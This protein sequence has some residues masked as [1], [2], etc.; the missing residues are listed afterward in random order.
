MAVSPYTDVE[1]YL[2]A[3]DAPAR[4]ASPVPG[5]KGL[6]VSIVV[7]A[8]GL[9]GVGVVM[10]FSAG[11]RVPQDDQLAQGVAF[12]GQGL[13]Q[14]VY[15]IGGL[16]AMLTMAIIPYRVWAARGGTPA[17]LL[18][19]LGLGLLTLVFLPGIGIE[20]KGAR[21]WLQLGPESLGLRFQPSELLKLALPVFL[22][23]WIAVRVEIRRF[24]RGFVPAVGFAGLCAGVVGLED[25]G[26]A[27]LLAAV[28]GAMLWVGGARWWHVVLPV[29]LALWAFF[30]LIVSR[31]HRVE[32]LVA[33][34]NIWADPE[35]TGYQAIQSL[36][37]IASGGW[38]GRGLGQGLV[39]AHLPEATNDF[40]F[41]VI[42]EELGVLGGAAVIGLLIGLLW[43][44]RRVVRDCP[45][46]M[47]RLLAFGIVLTLGLQAAM[48]IAVVTVSVPTKGISLPLV[49]AGG[50]GAICLGAM[51]GILANI[52]R[53]SR[54]SGGSGLSLDGED[55][56]HAG[57]AGF[58][59]ER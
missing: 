38:W 6:S 44:G 46:P 53:L 34:R 4:E 31:P 9:M 56:G 19:A 3:R 32:R 57:Q 30:H 49:S 40:I 59:A 58:Q 42:C 23:A 12:A 21:R 7:I 33:F 37:A 55:A 28:A 48:N 13:R 5:G 10:T 50:S 51:V 52:P 20:G 45:D 17:I 24:W 1:P 26:T 2:A 8:A 41:A 36:C 35:D 39:K 22:A 25:F 54:W 15:V 16:A 27:A 29:P 18:L 47:G 43:Q 11:A 14:L